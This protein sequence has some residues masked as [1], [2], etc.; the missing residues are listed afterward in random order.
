MK[1]HII[2]DSEITDE[3]YNEVLALLSNSKGILDFVS[4]NDYTCVISQDL[5]S[6]DELFEYCIEFRER[7]KI[8]EDSNDIVV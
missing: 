7:I 2:R 3:L 1:T 4:Y 6:H 8:R 5:L